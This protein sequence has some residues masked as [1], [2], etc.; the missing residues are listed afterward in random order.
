MNVLSILGIIFLALIAL[1]LILAFCAWVG[2][3]MGKIKNYR[4]AKHLEEDVT[5]LKEKIVRLEEENQGLKVAAGYRQ[6]GQ[7]TEKLS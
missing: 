6:I 5:F 7:T 2:E 4:Q 3:W 1:S